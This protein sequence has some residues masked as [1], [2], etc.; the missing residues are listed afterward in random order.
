MRISIL[1]RLKEISQHQD[2][3][4]SIPKSGQILVSPGIESN[5]VDIYCVFP[6]R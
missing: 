1:N 4:V 6:N 2:G 5:L 3:P